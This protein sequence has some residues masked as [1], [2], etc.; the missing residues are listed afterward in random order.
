MKNNT[1]K[2]LGSLLLLSIGVL[3]VL[4]AIF[5]T[6][7]FG[8]S[9]GVTPNPTNTYKTVATEAKKISEGGIAIPTEEIGYLQRGD[10]SGLENYL[11]GQ[12]KNWVSMSF[13]IHT[14]QVFGTGLSG[15][16]VETNGCKISKSEANIFCHIAT[17]I[18]TSVFKGNVTAGVNAE[19]ILNPRVAFKGDW[20]DTGERYTE[21]NKTTIVQASTVV[22][23]YSGRICVTSVETNTPTNV[24]E[25]SIPPEDSSYT[26]K[27][28]DERKLW[29]DLGPN[30]WPTGINEE[31]L[32]VDSFKMAKDEA[33]SEDKIKTI[34]TFVA[35][36]IAPGGAFY[37]AITAFYTPE[38]AKMFGVKGFEFVFQALPSDFTTR[39]DG[40]PIKK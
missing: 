9:S 15:M 6:N 30:I 7:T 8:G 1:N 26:I 22:I 36:D 27:T 14:N 39:C 4:G 31:K 5:L 40:T 16:T 17:I 32:R 25:G 13:N 10:L 20:T 33:L 29:P 34:Y 2:I 35:E 19:F 24:D 12:A 23:T 28:M 11:M 38:L 37:K 3:F 18:Y 21:G